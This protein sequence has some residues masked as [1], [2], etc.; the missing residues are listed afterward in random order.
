MTN[1]E[2]YKTAEERSE[3]FD[4]FCKSYKKCY[5]CPC[6]N[7]NHYYCRFVWLSLDAESE[8]ESKPVAPCPFCGGENLIRHRTFVSCVDCRACGPQ[9]DNEKD[10]VAQWN[11]R[12]NTNTNENKKGN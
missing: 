9:G 5:D 7:I 2:K 12:T 10:A 8:P 3:K 6:Y 11:R 1:E 4:D